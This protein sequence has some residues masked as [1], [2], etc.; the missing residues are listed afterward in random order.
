MKNPAIKL[1]EAKKEAQ[2]ELIEFRHLYKT[3][4]QNM[5]LNKMSFG[6]AKG[7]PGEEELGFLED[8]RKRNLDE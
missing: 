5:Q 1:V 3:K 8:A 4:E 7:K 6:Y 2:K